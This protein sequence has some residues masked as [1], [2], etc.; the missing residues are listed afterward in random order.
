MDTG[1]VWETDEA[2]IDRIMAVNFKG[3]FW[4]CKYA[5]R[6][7]IEQKSGVI[8]NLSSMVAFGKRMNT[9][10]VAKTAI[11]AITKGLANDLGPHNV[12]VNAIAP[13][14]IKTEM[15]RGIWSDAQRLEEITGHTPLRRIGDPSDIALVA[16]FL[17]SYA[18]RFITGQTI[19]VDGGIVP[20]G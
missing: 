5:A 11:I 1:N 8:L 6:R 19:L 18:A 14:I 20:F 17:A 7:M 12:R 16:L 2:K 10:A 9:Y 3:E 4:G 15:T 13:G